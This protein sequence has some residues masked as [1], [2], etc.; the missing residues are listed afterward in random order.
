MFYQFTQN[1]PGG[2]TI[3]DKAVGHK[4]VIEANDAEEANELAGRKVG[5]YFDGC[6][7]GLDC[8]CCGDRWYRVS[9]HDE[10]QDFDIKKYLDDSCEHSYD[11]NFTVII[12]YK[13]GKKEK[14]CIDAAKKR[15]KKKE[16]IRKKSEKL[17]ATSVNQY[18][19]IDHKPIEVFQSEDWTNDYWDRSGN[20]S[21]QKTGFKTSDNGIV[22]FASK[23]KQEVQDF[24]DE[25]TNLLKTAGLAMYQ[26]ESS[27]EA[28]K[29]AMLIFANMKIYQKEK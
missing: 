21:V 22:T 17:W 7:I 28:K 3:V 1:N 15:T 6:E 14:F 25:V 27:E 26:V 23:D 20:F 29:A 24:I 9:K 5:I 2:K 18:G 16:I 12:Y 4:V 13:D 8:N 10:I 19:V 11:E